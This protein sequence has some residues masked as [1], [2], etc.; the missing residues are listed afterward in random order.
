MVIQNLFN[1]GDVVYLKT[2]RD[3]HERIIV[4]IL[5]RPE[6]LLYDLACGSVDTRFFR[7]MEL[8]IEKDVLKS[9]TN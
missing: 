7:E 3:Q 1:I 4:G 6:G 9:T 5:V 2:D 8:S